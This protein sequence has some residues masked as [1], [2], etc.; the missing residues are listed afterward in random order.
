MSS[1]WNRRKRQQITRLTEMV[2]ELWVE[3]L[4]L[5]D[6]ERA[7]R[8]SMPQSKPRCA[9]SP[10]KPGR[11]ASSQRMSYSGCSMEQLPNGQGVNAL[12]RR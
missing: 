5:G 4:L 1:A 12:S 10:M 3:N 7:V 6:I 11:P 8:G 9:G 2:K